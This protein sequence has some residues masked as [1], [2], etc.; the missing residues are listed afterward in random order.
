MFR[1]SSE[2]PEAGLEI[3][4]LI[5]TKVPKIEIHAYAARTEAHFK[6]SSR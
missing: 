1:Q 3:R 4:S 2:E 6:R 5:K